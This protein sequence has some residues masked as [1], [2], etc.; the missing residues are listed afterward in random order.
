MTAQKCHKQIQANHSQKARKISE[1]SKVVMA[2]K[3][4]KMKLFFDNSQD[5]DK[6]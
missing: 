2:M 6:I 5:K 4:V 3:M 1:M